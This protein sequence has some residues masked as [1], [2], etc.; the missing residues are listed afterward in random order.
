MPI[1]M[2]SL[3]SLKKD[4][5]SSIPANFAESH[6]RDGRKTNTVDGL[7]WIGEMNSTDAVLKL[8][9]NIIMRRNPSS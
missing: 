3:K 5:L 1:Y 9:L 2:E 7:R 8:S 4:E 6:L